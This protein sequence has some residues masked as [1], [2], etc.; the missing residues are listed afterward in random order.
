VFENSRLNRMLFLLAD[1]LELRR[2]RAVQ[3]AVAVVAAGGRMISSRGKLQ[4]GGM[5]DMHRLCRWLLLKNG[6]LL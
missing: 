2:L 3:L 1:F 5:I 4:P 6:L